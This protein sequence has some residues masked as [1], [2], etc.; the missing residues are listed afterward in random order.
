MVESEIESTATKSEKTNIKVRNLKTYFFTAR[1][2][3][4]AIDNLSFDIRPGETFGLVGES[5]SGKSVTATSLI[6]LIP[7]PPGRVLQGSVFIEDFNIYGD[8]QKLASIEIKSETNVKIRRRKWAIKRHN[9]IVSRIRGKRISMIFQEPFLSL[10]PVLSIGDQLT[11]PILL[12]N[13]RELAASLVRRETISRKETYVFA[14]EATQQPDYEEKANILNKF[15]ETYALYEVKKFIK[16]SVENIQDADE[17]ADEVLKIVGRVKVGLDV[18]KFAELR[19][20]FKLNEML[21][22]KL[23]DL[24]MAESANNENQIARIRASITQIRTQVR[25]DYFQLYLKNI[26]SKKIRNKHITELARRKALEM[27]DLVSIASPEV[28]LNSYPHELSGGMLQ[29]VMIAMALS[30]SPRVLIADEPTTALDVTTQAQIL[31]LINDVID[32][33]KGQSVLF[34]T[35]DLAVI[36]EMCDRVGVMYGGNLVEESP[37]EKLFK[38]A[39]H[40]YTTGLMNSIPRH[41]RKADKVARLESI[42]GTVPDL[43]NPPTGCRFH[44]RCKFRM[45][46]CSEKKPKLVEIEPEHRVACFLYS[47]EVEEEE[48]EEEQ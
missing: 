24:I 30:S 38:D 16:E 13:A 7:D 35:H 41:D 21:G 25:T 33:R 14:E 46:V 22:S 2:I 40:P 1:G 9:K 20:Y 44:P 29:R 42:P 48:T 45:G 15:V 28:I 12:H 43:I 18:A 3:V 10:N 11:E 23:L 5:G 27:L 4:K 36:A 17:L 19:D 37:R 47:E 34:I 32:K 26:F 6:D 31:N 8:L 39:K